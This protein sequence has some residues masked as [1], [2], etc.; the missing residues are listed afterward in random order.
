MQDAV[1]CQE[2][3]QRVQR[4][5]TCLVQWCKMTLSLVTLAMSMASV[6]N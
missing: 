3:V 2:S 5:R 1:D 4:K 6:K